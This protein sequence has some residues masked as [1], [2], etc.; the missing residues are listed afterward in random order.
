VRGD[1]VTIRDLKIINSYAAGVAITGDYSYAINLTLDHIGETGIV[2]GGTGNQID[3]C[4][5]TDNGYLYHIGQCS[6]WGSAICAVSSAVNCVIQNCLSHD[7]GGEGINSYNGATGT[8]IQHNLVYDNTIVNV[9]VDGSSYVTIRHNLIYNTSANRVQG[10]MISD[11]PPTGD[12]SD[13]GLQI[14]NNL[15]INGYKNIY[16][17]PESALIDAVIA[18]NTLVNAQDT[19]YGNVV[20]GRRTGHSNTIFKNN[21]IKQD[22]RVIATAG[23]MSGITCSYNLWSQSEGNVPSS[24]RGTG[25]IYGQDPLLAGGSYSA[26]FF[27][28]ASNSP[29]RDAGNAISWITDDYFGTAKPQGS[30]VDMGGHEYAVEIDPNPRPM[31]PTN[32]RIV[33]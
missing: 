27:K 21:I 14:Y 6:S 32:L 19:E 5:V 17:T 25:D 26:D 29:A 4:T 23:S 30:A 12:E 7:N 18:Y 11:E 22:S 1:Y 2:A 8:I 24:L 31:A 9:Y 28:I 16:F 15:V 33:Y 3:G 20:F 13:I 10:I